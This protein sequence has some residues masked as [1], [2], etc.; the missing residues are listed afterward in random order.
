[1][2][3]FHDVRLPQAFSLG[4][5]GGPGWRTDVVQL[6]SGREFRNSP[7]AM[8]RRRWD[9]GGAIKSLED[10]AELTSF[11]EARRGRLHGFRFRDASVFS[12][13]VGDQA[14]TPT[15]QLLGFGDGVSTQ[16]QLVKRAISGGEELVRRITRPVTG[17]VRLALDG[18]EQMQGWTLDTATGVVTFSIAPEMDVQITA[19]FEFDMAVR[20]DSDQL[21]IAMDAFRAG[22]IVSAPVIELIE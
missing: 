21:D 16:F 4:A 20:F 3:G 14:I 22:R 13:A 18:T 1:M 12:S 2:S 17:T 7:W 19:G 8:S 9:I 6:A 5:T 10:L 11:F 15:D